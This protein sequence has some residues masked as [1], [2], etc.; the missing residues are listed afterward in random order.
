MDSVAISL[1][2]TK[3]IVNAAHH[4]PY[5]LSSVEVAMVI[6]GH[7]LDK[8]WDVGINIFIHKTPK[9]LHPIPHILFDT[10]HPLKSL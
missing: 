3:V 5:A 10:S 9:A 4:V 7:A 1:R 2:P 6:C 8:M